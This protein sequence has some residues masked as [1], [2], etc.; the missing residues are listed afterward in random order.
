M[1]SKSS[2]II[3]SYISQNS[4]DST[5]RL[6]TDTIVPTLSLTP[7]QRKDI[8][9]I[10]NAGLANASN[11][12]P[13]IKKV[14]ANNGSI[15]EYLF[16]WA[17]LYET[18]SQILPSARSSKSKG[19]PDDP[20]LGVMLAARQ[21]LS[22]DQLKTALDQHNLFMSAENVQGNLLEEYIAEKSKQYGWIWARGQTLRACDFVKYN[23]TTR[24]HDL[25]QIKNKYNTE[26]SSSKTIRQGTS[27]HHWFR[28]D[29]GPVDSKTKRPIPI[30]RW[31]KLNDLM[32]IPTGTMSEEDYNTF[33]KRIITNNPDII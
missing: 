1:T 16:K 3:S 33:L 29:K 20:A 13:Y 30:F 9:E 23:S 25:I 7:S 18:A 10:F 14:D 5:L 31:D 24:M 28:I 8:I 4:A 12:F 6:F 17:K 26:N 21:N 15:H 32:R 11:A 27:I 22:S 2:D 19:S